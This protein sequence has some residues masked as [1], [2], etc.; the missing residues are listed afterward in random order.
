MFKLMKKIISAAFT[1]TVIVCMTA[2]VA[3]REQGGV[4]GRVEA[5]ELL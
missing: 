2:I 3:Q 5:S 1:H 4:G